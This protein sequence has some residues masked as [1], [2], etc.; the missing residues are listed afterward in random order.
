M[1][2]KS[3]LIISTCGILV[4]CAQPALG[5]MYDFD[6]LSYGD[7]RGQDNWTGN[8]PW[9]GVAHVNTP[10]KV[11]TVPGGGAPAPCSGMMA[12]MWGGSTNPYAARVNDG[13]W[14][15]DLTGRTKFIL[16][17]HFA[18][19]Y[20]DADYVCWNRRNEVAIFNT[21][22]GKGIGFGILGSASGGLPYIKNASSDSVGDLMTSG[23]DP[24]FDRNELWDMRMEIDT[25]SY[26]GQGSARLYVMG[27][28]NPVHTTWTEIADI[29]GVYL[30]LAN[31]GANIQAADQV[32]IMIGTRIAP[33]DSIQV[34]IPSGTM[35]MNVFLDKNLDGVKNGSDE[36]LSGWA[37]DVAGPCDCGQYGH[38]PYSGT[39]DA[40]GQDVVT[41]GTANM[42]G[43]ED[44]DYAT[45]V[46]RQTY[47]TAAGG[48]PAS[49][50]V[51]PGATNTNAW[52]GFRPILGDANIDGTVNLSDFTILK[53]SFGND[54]A[55]WAAGNFN[56]DTTVNLADFTI[57]KAHFGEDH[58]DKTGGAAVPEPA[59]MGLLVLGALGLLRRRRS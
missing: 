30:H 15:F 24:G 46:T 52:F 16:G 26:G 27:R 51:A 10:I 4:T 44:G 32:R 35:T 18:I 48:N 37:H 55:G 36:A 19:D 1:K 42:P 49:V 41:G 3:L 31:S 23:S 14:S 25:T 28:T 40:S 5:V 13:A 2:L 12:T 47:Y 59:T 21:T 58:P 34:A 53:A 39:T 56:E 50:A 11:A 8:A 29:S 6:G 57:L 20:A 7:I 17:T 45:T 22:T 54:P 43:L 38:S 9:D 33:M